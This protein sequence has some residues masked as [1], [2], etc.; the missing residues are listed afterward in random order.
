MH[1][2][3]HVLAENSFW[4]DLRAAENIS[5]HLTRLWRVLDA[6]MPCAI[7]THRDTY[8]WHTSTLQRTSRLCGTGAV[9]NL[10]CG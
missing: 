5:L 4:H 1:I 10:S 8:Q 2:S 9:L 6:S 7:S 3:R